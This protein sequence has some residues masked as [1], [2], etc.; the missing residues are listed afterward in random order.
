MT[1]YR[2]KPV[3]IK[4]VQISIPMKVKTLEGTMKGNVGDWLITGFKGEQ[5]FCKDEIFKMTYE[6]VEGN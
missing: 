4:A 2:K 3:V 1:Q 6:I 5:Y